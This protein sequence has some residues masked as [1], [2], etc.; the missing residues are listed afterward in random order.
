MATQLTSNTLSGTYKDDYADSAGYHQ[1]LF[2]SGKALQARELTQMQT[3]LQKQISRFGNNIFRE[4]AVVKPG[5]QAL[6]NGYEFIKLNTT[7]EGL[8]ATPSS[9][10]GATYTGSTSLVEFKVLEVVSASG[11][12]PATLYVQY[13]STINSTKSTTTPIKV[14][15]GE[16]LTSSSGK[17]L[18]VQTTD[19]VA[20]PAIGTGIKYSID[21]GIY[22]AKGFFIFTERQSLI[23]SKYSD[24]FTGDLGYK[25][26]E[27]VHTTADDTSLFDNQ[28]ATPNIAAPGA[29]RL[30]ISLV[31]SRRSDLAGDE[32]FIQI[33]RIEEG[34]LYNTISTNDAYNI[35]NEVMATRIKENSGD[36][37]VKQFKAYFDEDS[38]NTHLLL[39]VSDGIV[40]VDGYRAAKNSPTDIRVAKATDTYQEENEFISI[41]FGN[42]VIVDPAATSGLP[43]ID[44]F[45][46]LNI[47]DT[48][49]YGG[50]TIG[51]CRVRHISEDGANY[52]YHLFDIVMNSGSQFEDGKSIG[53][54]G[55]NYFNPTLTSGRAVRYETNK[56]TML[57]PLP[58]D[59]PKELNVADITLTI[60]ERLTGTFS[61]NT[62][63]ISTS[64]GTLTNTGDWVVSAND[65]A[66]I[67]NFSV[68]G[69]LTDGTA[70]VTATNGVADGSNYEFIVYTAKTGTPRS[71]TL[72][73]NI[74]TATIESDG[75]GTAFL[76]LGKPDIYKL[77]EVVNKSDSDEDYSGYFNLDNG[78]RDNFYG[79]GRLVL[80]GG[81]TAPSGDVHIEYQYFSHGTSGD[82]FA[83]NSYTG[84]VEYKDIP[85]YNGINLRDVIDFRSVKNSSGTFSGGDARVHELPQPTDTIQADVTYYLPQSGTLAIDTDGVLKYIDGTSSITPTYPY[86][87][88]KHMA[89]YNF[90]LN[91]NTLHDSDLF[92]SPVYNKRYTMSN[93][94]ELEKRIDQ[95][96]EF[97]ALSLL[98]VGTETLVLQDSA[99]SDR[100]KAGFLV[101]N[102]STQLLSDVNNP[103]YAA[104]IDPLYRE[105]HP[106]F[107]EDNVRLIF[108]SDNSSGVVKRGDNIYLEYT[109][110]EYI[111]QS[112]VSQAEQINPFSV[113]TYEGNITLSPSSDEWRETEYTDKKI[114]DNGTALNTDQAK[115]WNN[116][117]WSWGGVNINDLGVG[118]KTQSITTQNNST[119]T[120]TVVNKVVSEETVLDYIQDV[121]LY[122]TLIPYMRSKK[123][124]FKV[125]GVTPNQQFFA[126]FDNTPVADWVREETFQYY[127]D[128]PTDYGNTQFNAT[129]HPES[130]SILTSNANGEIEGSFFIPNTAAIK[131]KTGSREFKLL[132]ISVN[133]DNDATSFARN[134]YVS[135]GY[136]D[137]TQQEYLS[138]RILYVEGKTSVTYKPKPKPKN[139]K[140][141]KYFASSSGRVFRVTGGGFYNSKNSYSNRST[142][143]SIAAGTRY[144]DTDN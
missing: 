5:P 11:S 39:K 125:T 130:K 14:T 21:S 26:V 128:N 98:E 1:I 42:Y 86:T 41:D 67:Q 56:N 25:I 83:V 91:P 58:L 81:Q 71:K 24:T 28:G 16:T 17:N 70:T 15:A 73:T 53:T 23:V 55:T 106:T 12:D 59:R 92:V 19:T 82:F 49:D 2:N 79:Q 63:D 44:T 113:V 52:R 77:T 110:T 96:E 61:S 65:S 93:I 129:E 90:V 40:V 72:E 143:N 123:V 100:L 108:D 141:A 84:Q 64:T 7:I 119:K 4:G 118:S 38:S 30:K 127:A 136:L 8:P 32:N 95:L 142:A 78:Q 89:L 29:D 68:S 31:L 138:T 114:I 105:L 104:A 124:F 133:N 45:E 76:D 9:L 139:D 62:A 88:E 111:D 37:T 75:A 60:Q 99:G 33:S 51:T 94:N 22:F 69:T 43:N 10:V 66:V 74:I 101:D 132:N 80:K 115:L 140:D 121:V 87:P 48:I 46:Q 116:H 137:T 120:T 35:P 144:R 102:F 97:T 126:F 54:S 134:L 47:R 20:N 18:I 135:T 6:N 112:V 34:A 131:F 27:E 103:D 107:R 50:S 57:F 117:N 122:T 109:E 13:T 85:N 36:Y 3:I